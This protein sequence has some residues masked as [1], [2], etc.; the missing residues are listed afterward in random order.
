MKTLNFLTLLLIAGTIGFS[1]CKK[2][3]DETTT[4]DTTETT[5]KTEEIT[6]SRTT[7]YGEDWIY[8]SFETNSEV[9][10]IDTNNYTTSTKWDIAF[11]RN[12][13]RTNSGLSGIGE[14]G[15]YDAG[16]VDFSSIIKA[17]ESGYMADSNIYIVAGFNPD[18]SPIMLETT[19]SATFIGCIDVEMGAQG[20]TYPTNDH[21]YVIKTANGK[22]AKVLI[23]GFYNENGDSGYINFK[24]SY[25]TNGSTT[26]E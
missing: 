6:L 1:S 22:Y 26:L 7:N 18:H 3:D 23:K 16:K 11:N 21:I 15:V 10:G 9:S 4:N 12:N 8:F 13:V 25:Q 20:P 24:Y 5:L 17:N 2:D 14:G 19:G